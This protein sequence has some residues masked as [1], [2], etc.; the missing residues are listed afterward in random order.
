MLDLRTLAG[1]EKL[2]FKLV[3]QDKTLTDDLKKW[4]R[5]I[6]HPDPK[7]DKHVPG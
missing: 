2:F 6:A 4:R 3:A 7:K 5:Q 1:K